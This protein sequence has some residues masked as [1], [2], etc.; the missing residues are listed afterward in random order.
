MVCA[1]LILH[2]YAPRWLQWKLTQ[3]HGVEILQHEIEYLE[4]CLAHDEVLIERYNALTVVQDDQNKAL[5]EGIT[6]VK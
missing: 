4:R 6:E 2:D 1:T 3:T 5:I